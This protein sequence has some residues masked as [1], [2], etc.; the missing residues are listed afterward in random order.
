MNCSDIKT[1][2]QQNELSTLPAEVAVHTRTCQ[3]CRAELALSER[4]EKGLHVL[5][6]TAK[7]P[8]LSQKILQKIAL[9]KP[10]PAHPAVPGS[11]LERLQA[12]FSGRPQL[13]LAC[14]ILLFVLGLAGILLRHSRGPSAPA[15]TSPWSVQSCSAGTLID[16]HPAVSGPLTPTSAFAFSTPVSGEITLKWKNT[17]EVRLQGASG[18]LLADVLQL[19]NGSLRVSTTGPKA[20]PPLLVKTAFGTVREIGTIFLVE[21]RRDEMKVQVEDGK[22]M[23]ETPAGS[24]DVLAG[25]TVTV[26]RSGFVNPVPVPLAT[27]S[28]P[29]V[30]RVPTPG[31]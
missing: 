12:L 27:P 16:R 13:A 11:W 28:T 15:I 3:A 18:Q 25:Q 17:S 31:E 4:L 22:V 24:R 2:I 8:D 14:A 9:A 1:L 29:P 10:V 19:E 23:V 7:P 26:T 6:K 5:A 21:I 30:D 20:A